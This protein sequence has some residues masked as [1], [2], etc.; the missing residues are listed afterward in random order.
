MEDIFYD[1]D[2]RSKEMLDTESYAK[3]PETY[4]EAI[5]YNYQKNMINEI[6]DFITDPKNSLIMK[7]DLLIKAIGQDIVVESYILFQIT[8][9]FKKL[10][11]YNQD[12]K[13]KKLKFL[14][15][16]VESFKRQQK[17]SS[18]EKKKERRKRYPEFLSNS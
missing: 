12:L 1:M 9:E 7:V 14:N 3:D 11:G 13:N 17:F 2:Y 18:K 6:V 10:C 5:S 16:E 8:K 4:Y 15:N